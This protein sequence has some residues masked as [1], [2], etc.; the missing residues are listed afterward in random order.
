MAKLSACNL[1]I[2]AATGHRPN[3]AGGYDDAV[4]ARLQG[5]THAYLRNAIH[6]YGVDEITAIS[7]V[8]LGWDTAYALAALD[9]DIPLICAVPFKG[10]ESKWPEK[11]QEIYRNILSKAWH[12]EVIW[13]GGYSN[14]AFQRRNEFMV[15]RCDR[16]C[17]LWD[18]SPGGTG[19]CIKYAKSL[20]KPPPIDNLWGQWTKLE[21]GK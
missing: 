18:G 13:E 16:L 15:N 17:A 12:V 1:T 8:A 2:I 6:Q 10:Q 7:G 21:V 9:L 11:S 19:N 5:L 20:A 3:K 14:V 4:A